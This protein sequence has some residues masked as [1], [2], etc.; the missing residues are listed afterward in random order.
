MSLL[1]VIHY[2]LY[3]ERFFSTV[4]NNIADVNKA[5]RAVLLP[6][7]NFHETDYLKEFATESAYVKWHYRD[8]GDFMAVTKTPMSMSD[9]KDAVVILNMRRGFVYY[10]WQYLSFD[11]VSAACAQE[12]EM[13][14]APGWWRVEVEY[15][16]QCYV[17]TKPQRLIDVFFSGRISDE[18]KTLVIFWWV[19][20]CNLYAGD[21]FRLEI[22]LLTF[23]SRQIVVSRSSEAFVLLRGPDAVSLVRVKNKPSKI[24]KRSG[25]GVVDDG[26]T[27]T[28]A[29]PDKCRK[30]H[31]D[32]KRGDRAR[33][34][35]GNAQWLEERI[36]RICWCAAAFVFGYFYAPEFRHSTFWKTQLA[37]MDPPRVTRVQ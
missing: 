8:H 30:R 37:W 1:R 3:C 10:A 5:I 28:D 21:F 17:C 26:Q 22:S 13:S 23:L 19:H 14:D 9:R 18:L 24:A 33:L 16:Y 35:I 12:K 32:V 20:M 15:L 7:N 34:Q 27:A 2:G 11:I 4:G 25:G 6:W 36:D 29:T 31:N